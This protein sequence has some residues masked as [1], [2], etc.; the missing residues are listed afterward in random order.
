MV[1]EK[2]KP[3]VD[4]LDA[5][6]VCAANDIKKYLSLEQS[7]KFPDLPKYQRNL[8][9]RNYHTAITYFKSNYFKELNDFDGTRIVNRLK[10]ICK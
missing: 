1:P 7:G 10:E 6:N 9:Y 3:W 2:F 4:L 5:V 8:L